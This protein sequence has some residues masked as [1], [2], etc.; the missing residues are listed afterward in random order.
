MQKTVLIAAVIVSLGY[1]LLRKKYENG[2]KQLQSRI[3]TNQ[4]KHHLT[5]VFANAKKRAVS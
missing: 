1:L 2:G 3:N 5:E 4:K